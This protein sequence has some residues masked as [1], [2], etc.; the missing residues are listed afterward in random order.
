M[1]LALIVFVVFFVAGL[2]LSNKT[3]QR[4]SFLAGVLGLLFFPIGVIL[5]LV[6]NYK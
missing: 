1:G 6:K 4:R 3:R 2:A 5:A